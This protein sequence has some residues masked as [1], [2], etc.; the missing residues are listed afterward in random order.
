MYIARQVV[1]E[2]LRLMGFAAAV[3]I[4]DNRVLPAEEGAPPTVIVDVEGQDLG[5]LIGRRGEVL[6]A[7]QFI[8][9]LIVGRRIDHRARVIVVVEHYWQ[10]REANLRSLAR[11]MADRVRTSHRPLSLEPMPAH[12]RRII[13]LTLAS[14]PDVTTQ[15]TGEGDNRKV[16]IMPRP[17]A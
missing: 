3:S 16:V 1:S 15:S 10:R 17:P 7:L 5:M 4:R 14:D 6:S 9:N 13:H 8:T 12:E 2:L 11:R